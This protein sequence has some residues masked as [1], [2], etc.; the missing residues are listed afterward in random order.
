MKSLISCCATAGVAEWVCCPGELNTPLI[1][2]L[3]Q[4]PVVHRWSQSDERTAAYFALGRIQA[5]T[6]PVAVVA[7]SG[8]TATALAPAVV[9][10]YYQRRPL[11]IITVEDKENAGGSGA[12]GRI[13][14]EGLFGI[15]APTVEVQLPCSVSD[16]P[17]LVTTCAE[18]FP[19]H[20]NLRL[21]E[22]TRTGGDFTGLEVAEPPAAPPFR[23][24]LVALSQMLRFRA[25]EGL[26]L[27]IGG[28]DAGEQEP[29]IW[30]ARTLRVPVIAEATSGLREELH[31]FLLHGADTFLPRYAP[32]YVLRV[33]DVPTCAFWRA[34]EDLPGTE[35]FSITRTGFSGLCRKSTVIEGELEQVMKALGDVP[36]IGDT[37]GY[38]QRSRRSAGR[39]E[40]LLL[41]YPES[42]AAMVRYFSNQAGIAD[43]LS[44]GSTTTM[45]LWNNYAQ[46]QVPTHYVRANS[47]TGGADGTVSA[48][49]ANSIDADYA[50]CLTGDLA[51]LRDCAAAS[52]IPQLPPARRV[53]AV[54][55]NEGAGQAYTPGMDDELQRLLVQPPVY[56]LKEVANL[57][58]AEYYAIHCEA[59]FEVLDT[60]EPTAFAL[61][62]IIPDPEQTAAFNARLA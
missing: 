13:E 38:L 17:D 37:E 8:A 19:V 44:L 9:E 57:W 45:R 16:L 56:D 30:L 20:L 55:N 15:Y 62:D 12:P 27:I 32:R 23:A 18:G 7:G 39:I 34:L 47:G 5:T 46:T 61:L 14:T 59:D 25:V 48:F 28:L 53:V 35:V 52:M 60:L 11:I 54:L 1:T 22:G 36:H 10:A 6:R 3:A 26:V 2:T 49:L 43:V 21:T 29:A 42:E 24:S 58:G 40:E 4:C 33:G 51:L 41:A 31:P 50:C